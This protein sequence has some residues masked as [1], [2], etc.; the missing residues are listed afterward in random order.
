M[1]DL[2]RFGMYLAN[3]D[4]DAL[5]R[6]DVPYFDLTSYALGIDEQPAEIVYFTR[7]DCVVCGTEEVAEVFRRLDITLDKAVP[8]GTAVPAMSEIV[9]GH[10]TA[11]KLHM[12]W[13]VGQNLLDHMSGIATKTR[14]MVD[15][16]H[17]V[18]PELAILTTRKMYPGTKALST[19][20][21]MAG[22]AFPHRLGLSETVLVFKQHC[23]IIGGFDELLRR[24]PEMKRQC[25]EKKILVE[26]ESLENAIALCSAGVDGIQFDKLSAKETEAAS[27]VLNRR[28]PGVIVLAA[29]G[30]NE[31]NVSGYAAAK[32]SGVVTTSL[33]NAPAIDIG[34]KINLCHE[35]V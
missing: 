17:A 14:Q 11:G 2:R 29:G 8:S 24:L 31:K 5:I 30:I 19:K 3:V 10:G 9:R 34:V 16:A 28:F 26:T 23:N 22:G 1:A 13:K 25:C 15:A 18:N 4:F 35:K 33:Y 20:A 7:E 32:I 27:E 12:A 21:V 6:E